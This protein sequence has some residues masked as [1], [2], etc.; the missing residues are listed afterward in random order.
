MSSQ[1]KLA[2]VVCA[3]QKL[4]P[5]NAATGDII[6]K[7]YKIGDV[8]YISLQKKT[9]TSAQNR[10]L[11]QF[12]ED[13]AITFNDGGIDQRAYMAALKEGVEISW[14]KESVKEVIWREFQKALGMPESTTRLATEEVTRIHMQ[15]AKFVAERFGIICPPF[16]SRYEE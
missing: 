11:H 4:S 9:R 1:A 13:L 10:A 14:S 12:C 8:A 16:P 7:A 2:V 15:I 6:A 3:E 5:Y